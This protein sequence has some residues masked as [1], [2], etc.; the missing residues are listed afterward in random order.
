NSTFTLF[1][2]TTLFRSYFNYGDRFYV[3]FK[4]DNNEEAIKMRNNFE[5]GLIPAYG[6]N[7]SRAK[8]GKDYLMP[9][10]VDEN[11]NGTINEEGRI[12]DRKCTR[13]NS[14]HVSI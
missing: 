11:G 13:L 9:Y 3:D 14:S 5:E 7:S 12:G 4:Y 10:L 1:S 6:A 8:E 2:Y